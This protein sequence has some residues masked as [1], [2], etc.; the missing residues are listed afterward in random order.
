MA[1]SEQSVLKCL[2]AGKSEK[3]F[4]KWKDLSDFDKDQIVMAEWPGQSIS[5]M[6]WGV[7]SMQWLLVLIKSS[8]RMD[9]HRT[10]VRV[11][12][13]QD[14]LM[15]VGAKATLPGHTQEATVA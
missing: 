13:P 9:N 11:M 4:C 2:W 3:I 10:G 5:K 14:S 8:A 12:G 1:A 6:S 15:H 7:P